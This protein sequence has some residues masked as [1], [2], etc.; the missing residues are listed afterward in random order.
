MTNYPFRQVVTGVMSTEW[1]NYFRS[2]PLAS[3]PSPLF[4]FLPSSCPSFFPS[5]LCL[6]LS[7]L[8]LF[9]SFP[10][11]SLSAP[12]TTLSSLSSFCPSFFSLFLL[13]FLLSLS[14]SYTSSLSTPRLVLG[15]WQIIFKF[16]FVPLQSVS[17][18]PE[19]F[20]CLGGKKS[21]DKIQNIN[22]S[23]RGC[24]GAFYSKQ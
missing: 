16:N 6:L 18:S 11:F 22:T 4:L 9:P 1:I 23:K 17:F 7:H 10:L 20:D 15:I 21:E 13:H 12:S 8:F 3:I 2:F 5:L 14:F 19:F 24:N